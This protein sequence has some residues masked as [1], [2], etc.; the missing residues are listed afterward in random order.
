MTK[1]LYLQNAAKIFAG[2]GVNITPNGRPYLGAALGS[3]DF[4]EEHLRSKVG[5]WTSSI[6]LLSEIAKSQ[7][8]A[9]YSA[10][11]HGLSSKWSYLSRVTPNIS[12]LLI[13]L[14]TALITE[15]LPA[16]T[17]R[18][19]PNDQERALFALPA[20]YGGLGIRIPSKNAEK[21]LQSSQLVT[22]SLVSHILEQNQEYGYDIIADQLQSKA[23]IR[24]RN[25]E[26][27]SKEA[28][29]LY[30]HLPAQ[31]QKAV[32]LAKEK[33]ASTWLTALPLKEHG[34]SLHRAAFH[35]AMALRYRWSPSNLPSMC[36]CGNHFT[37]EHV[38]SCAKGGFPSIRHNEIHDLTA[39]LL[40][41]SDQLSG[42]TANSQDGARLDV[43]ANGVW[44]GRFEN[45]FFDVR[46]F[47][48]HAPSNKNQTLSA[49]Y[50][51]HEK[52]KKRVYEQR[53]REVEHSSFTPLVFS[54]TGGMG[55]EATCFYKRLASMLAQKWDHP[56][57]TTLCWLRCRLTF[58]LI[59]S[60]I[61]ALRGARSS[62][63]Q[64]AHSPAAI[65]L[66][67]TES[68]ITPDF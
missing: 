59:R 64:A 34:F 56:Y 39:N 36:D 66:A 2:S 33:G 24:N 68:Y 35:D 61:Q 3:P 18:P 31:L 37:V 47:N 16:L 55:R 43:S 11:V 14:D 28:D 45:T 48:P 57:S 51:K 53:I 22:S 1:D 32:D 46:V 19:T 8:H 44:G 20:R 54:A 58:S 60:A 29:D 41:T 63:G 21:E 17:G 9:A 38:L 30:S 49:C 67:I 62:R 23:T 4:I 27:S 50:R 65:D 26:M 13:P 15:L 5:E 10:L 6:T 25:K 12:H 52:E 42:A 40:T 7:P